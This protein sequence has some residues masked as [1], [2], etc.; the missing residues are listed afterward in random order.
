[1]RTIICCIFGYLFLLL[2]V[3][4]LSRRPGAQLTPFE[5]VLVF[6]IGGVIILS[7]TV[8][9][10]SLTNCFCGVLTVGLM[11]RFVAYLRQR[12]PRIG[13]LLDGTPL[14]LLKNGQWQTEIMGTMRIQDTDVLATA[15]TKGLRSISQVKYAILERNGAI[16]IVE[17]DG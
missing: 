15:R 1:M 4:V 17:K 2:I 6:L 7:V 14:V 12:F 11:H 16:S 3:R 8:D 5:F 13:I 9:D 10:R